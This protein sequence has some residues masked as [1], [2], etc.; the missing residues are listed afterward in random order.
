MTGHDELNYFAHLS[1]TDRLLNLRSQ[2]RSTATNPQNPSNFV[3]RRSSGTRNQE[4]IR[5]GHKPKMHHSFGQLTP[6][7]QSHKTEN[8]SL[9]ASW[10]HQNKVLS[11]CGTTSV[12]D[13]RSQ[14]PKTARSRTTR[15]EPPSKKRPLLYQAME[16][17]RVLPELEYSSGTGRLGCGYHNRGP[18]SLLDLRTRS[19]PTR[20][21]L[22]K[23]DT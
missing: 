18:I 5:A 7:N 9:F 14:I 12:P 15:P 16:P 20:V 3:S 4:P 6:S 22:F 2:L 13:Y 21:V 19:C 23:R 10:E 11:R 8:N 1:S 17:V